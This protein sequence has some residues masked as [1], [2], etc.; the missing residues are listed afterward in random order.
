MFDATLLQDCLTRS[1]SRAPDDVALVFGERRVSYRELARSSDA[2]AASLASLGV[3]RG[4]RVLVFGHNA[5]ELAI[6]F[7]AVVK[8]NAVVCVIN[9]QTPV[10]R[11]AWYLD[12]S[13]A[14]AMIVDLAL[15]D[16]AVAACAG[17]RSPVAILSYGEARQEAPFEEALTWAEALDGGPVPQ[18]ACL[19]FDLAAIIYTSGSSGEPKGVMLTHRN[20]LAATNSIAQYLGLCADDCLLGALPLSFDYGLYQLILAVRVGARLLIERSFALP[21]PVLKRMA[22][23]GVTTLAGVPTW[24]SLLEQVPAGYEVPSLRRVTSSGA[25]LLAS[26]LATLRARFPQAEI[27]S[28]YGLTEC[29]R[30]TYVPPAELARKPESVGIAIPNTEVWVVDEHDRRLG[31]DQPGQLVVRG[32]TVMRGYWND[33]EGTLER[34]K[35]GPLPG[36]LVL[37]TGDLCTMDDEGFV[38]VIGRM[39]DMIKSRGEKVSPREVELALEAIPGVREAAVIGVPDPVQGTKIKAYVVLTHA[40]AQS[41]E[42]LQRACELRLERNKVPSSIVV[43]EDFKKS[44]NGKIDKRSLGD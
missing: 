40:G 35:P 37:Y 2:V 16:V 20:M 38:T 5:L 23:E 1:A 24:F 42:A 34:L 13:G 7:W 10:G 12:N 8:A 43:V 6:S 11:L 9:S 4:D 17:A 19:E 14:R 15:A 3:R 31:P 21:R 30:C 32:P 41:P 25:R 36:E 29:K 22:T 28:M 33:P 44:A 26:H 18:R 39:D 27:F